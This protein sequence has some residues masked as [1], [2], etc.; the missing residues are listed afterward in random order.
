MSI[1]IQKILEDFGVSYT[2]SGKHSRP[3]WVQIECPLCSGNPGWHGGFNVERAYYNCWRCGWHPIDEVLH[4]ATNQEIHQI[5]K[6]IKSYQTDWVEEEDEERKRTVH[7]IEFPTGTGP[8]QESHKKYLEGRKLDPDH[9]EREWQ[10]LGTGPLG[11]YKFRIIA[12][13]YHQDKIVSY[14]GRDITGRSNLPYKACPKHLEVIHHKHL[15]YGM[16]KVRSENLLI[17]EGV[18]DV[19]NVGPGTG[20]TF[21]ID[22]TREQVAKLAKFQG[23]IFIM[24][25]AEEEKAQEKAEELSW[26]LFDSD[27]IILDYG[28]PG[29]LSKEEVITLRKDLKI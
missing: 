16:D 7:K 5:K 17:V 3:G 12:P 19:W 4:A 2:T 21:G 10:I 11:D 23:T 14:Q 25:D 13:I 28:D 29:E 15:I 8:L 18:F 1:D 6:L 22:F 20:A 26:Q 27:T 9:L 24:Y